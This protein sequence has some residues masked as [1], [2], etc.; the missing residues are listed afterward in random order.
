M[1]IADGKGIEINTS[2]HRY[3]LKDLTP[4]VDILRLYR[5]LGGRI[6]TIGSDS[7]R[8]EHLGA[9]IID[10]MEEAKK[11]GFEEIYT[12]DQMRPIAHKL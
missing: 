5:E 2:S 11:L 9:Y 12:F 3:G 8:K 1:V 10:T 4:S 7:H 6:L